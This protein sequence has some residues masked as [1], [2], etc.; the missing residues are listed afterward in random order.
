MGGATGAAMAA[1]VMIFEM[2]LDYTVIVPMT[3]TVAISYGVRR[4][5]DQRQH[6]YA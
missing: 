3:L 6:L 2:T 1:I 5:P 4:S